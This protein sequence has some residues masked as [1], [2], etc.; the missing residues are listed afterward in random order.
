MDVFGVYVPSNSAREAASVITTLSRLI[1]CSRRTLAAGDFN[2][3]IEISDRLNLQGDCCGEVR[4]PLAEMWSEHLGSLNLT[5]MTNG[6]STF[7]HP[8]GLS[9]IDRIYD[10]LDSTDL[11]LMQFASN[12][13][14]F[15]KDISDHAPMS[16][17]ISPGAG[18]AGRIPDW[19]CNLPD[20]LSE[21]RTAFG[22]PVITNDDDPFQLLERFSG[23][24]G[25]ITS[26]WATKAALY[27]C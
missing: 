23:E 1:D 26:S 17:T 3:T 12:T 5:D 14:P 13:I 7:N 24:V 18:S 27:Q 4:H 25:H 15:N 10:N 8:H 11:M 21:V 22:H 19:I 20:L 2:F 16:L 9:R 6:R